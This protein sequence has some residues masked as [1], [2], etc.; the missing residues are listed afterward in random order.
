MHLSAR[1]SGRAIALLLGEKVRIT[2]PSNPA[3]GYCWTITAVDR[4]VLSFAD[5]VFARELPPPAVSAG[6][7][8]TWELR[9]EA[10]GRAPLRLEYRRP[11]EDGAAHAV[12]SLV[13]TVLPGS[14]LSDPKAHLHPEGYFALVLSRPS[15][16]MLRERFA[17]LPKPLAH[18]CTVRYGSQ[19]PAELPARFTAADLGQTFTLKVIGHKTRPDGAIQAAAV[20]LVGEGGALVEEGFS[21]NKV[22]HITVATNGLVSAVEANAL[23]EEGFLRIHGPELQATLVHTWLT[24]EE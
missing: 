13:V 10:P 21:T 24:G 20:A 3:T 11:W 8:E 14:A 19:D 5:Q 7:H 23:L 17:T 4:A 2:L 1:D 6:G 16:R 22:P 18:H 12:F 9:A 15:S